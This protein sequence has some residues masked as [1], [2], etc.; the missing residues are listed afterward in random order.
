[1]QKQINAYTQN[2]LSPFLCGYRKGYNAQYALTVMLEKWKQCL[3]GKGN[4]GAILMD[5]SKAF[6]TIHHELLIA[7]LGA[8]GFSESLLR[9][10]LNYLSNRWQR[11]KINSSFSTWS[12][13]LKGVPQGSVLGPLL[14]NLYIID[15]FFEFVNTH[16]CNF[17]DDTSLNA[18]SKDLEELFFNLETDTLSAIIWF[19][20]NYMKINR[21]KCHF[22]ISAN[23]NEYLYTKVGEELYE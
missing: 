8:Y 20:N 17:A 9:I 16:P 15:L 2:L 1:M 7:K 4:A 10:I 3:D 19:Q 18:F 5:L 21:D 11:T 14:F 22:L 6:D 13:L 12:E 23:T